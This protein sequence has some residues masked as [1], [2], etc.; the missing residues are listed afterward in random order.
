MPIYANCFVFKFSNFVAV[1]L[2]PLC[3]L[4]L[5]I[6]L[7]FLYIYYIYPDYALPCIYNYFILLYIY[8]LIFMLQVTNSPILSQLLVTYMMSQV[9]QVSKFM[10]CVWTIRISDNGLHQK[11][12]VHQHGRPTRQ[13]SNRLSTYSVYTFTQENYVCV[14]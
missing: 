6:F 9:T 12:T 10:R 13:D 8:I 3:N 2:E 1:F 4:H 14:P 11:Q 5:N 7:S